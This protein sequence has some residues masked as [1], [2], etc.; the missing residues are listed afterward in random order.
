MTKEIT[1]KN[2]SQELDWNFIKEK[3]APKC[4]NAEFELLCEQA[5]V[6]GANPLKKDCYFVSHWNTRKQQEE[7]QIWYSIDFMRKRAQASKEHQATIREYDPIN[8]TATVKIYKKEC[9][10]AFQETVFLRE[11]YPTNEKKQTLWKKMPAQMLKKCCEATV[12]RMAWPELFE[13]V[14]ISEE[15]DQSINNSNE[16]KKPEK[17]QINKDNFFNYKERAIKAKRGKDFEFVVNGYCMEKNIDETMFTEEDYKNLNIKI[18]EKFK[19]QK[20]ENNG[21]N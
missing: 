18:I 21:T 10:I 6:T 13:H 20:E 17:Q 4:P 2:K 1:I 12:L 11:F 14:Y 15:M 9:S 8:H 5:K 16:N 19:N 3:F 7:W